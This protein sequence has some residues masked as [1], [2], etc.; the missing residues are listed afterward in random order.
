M[1]QAQ[2]MKFTKICTILT[3]LAINESSWNCLARL[4]AIAKINNQQTETFVV[5]SAR[6]LWALG[7]PL[8]LSF[9]Y[10]DENQ[11]SSSDI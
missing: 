1:N 9:T 2:L 5:C 3:C 10:S 8:Y 11:F 6:D 4:T 7:T